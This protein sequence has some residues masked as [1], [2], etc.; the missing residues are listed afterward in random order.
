[1]AG[2]VPLVDLPPEGGEERPATPGNRSSESIA[3]TNAGRAEGYHCQR[4]DRGAP[5]LSLRDISPTR[6]ETGRTRPHS[7]HRRFLALG[8]SA[9]GLRCRN[10]FLSRQGRGVAG[11]VPP[12][13][14]S[15]PCGGDARQGRGGITA[16]AKIGRSPPSV[17]SADISP[18]RGRGSG[19]R[20]ASRRQRLP[21]TS[22]KKAPC[23]S[24]HWVT[25]A[26][27][28]TSIGAD[29]T[30][31]PASVTRFIAASI[32]GTTK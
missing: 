3:A 18:T 15:P 14:S 17:G 28:G 16:G 25:Q 12:A 29:R 27:P 8:P 20:I 31:P 21:A 6:G 5:P 10:R 9:V 22:A 1:M 24:R 2:A 11:A 4:R 13:A 19:R 7:P 30:V 32:S 23:G 26:P